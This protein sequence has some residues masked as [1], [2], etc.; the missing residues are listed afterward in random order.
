VAPGLSR[1]S[2]AASHD[3]KA[4]HISKDWRSTMFQIYRKE[5]IDLSRD[6]R[7]LLFMLVLPTLLIPILMGGFAYFVQDMV[8]KDQEEVLS[9]AIVGA[10]NDPQLAR[11]LLADKQFQR[12]E[13]P[14]GKGYKAAVR[15]ELVRFVVVVPDKAVAELSSGKAVSID[16]YLNDAVETNSAFQRLEKI[17]DAQAVDLQS[18][19][20]LAK[21][22]HG[23]E[24]VG[25]TD[26]ISIRKI[27]TASVRE[28]I[29][30]KLGSVVPYI[31]IIVCLTGVMYPAIDLG[32]GE[33]ER[34]TLETLLLTP[35]PRYQIVLAKF[36]VLFTTGFLSVFL[37]IA[38]STA[39]IT[40]VL[41][42]TST[43]ATSLQVLATLSA[44]SGF[45]VAMILLMLVPVSAM[46]AA[47]LLSLSIYAR[48]YKE[49]QSY[50]LP[51]IIVSLLPVML[52]VLPGVSLTWGWAAVPLTNVAL[53]IKEICKGT[54][55]YTKFIAIFGSSAVIAALCIALCTWWFQRE[56]VLFRT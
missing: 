33:K 16:M 14:A 51:L 25:V 19:R 26:P 34:G 6:K 15:D 8:K 20:L 46:F 47:M 30:E 28:T 18:Q 21:G 49:A 56:S 38:S 23:D 48:G 32:V 54:I 22:F 41:P 55:D 42:H 12:V 37:T 53:A 39:W 36:F 1:T 7:A 9:Y 35:V 40:L 43:D 10:E 17:V 29:G 45:D 3:G 44:V 50:T 24:I 27:S 2:D 13:L 31:L 11:E 4:A 5:L 52:A